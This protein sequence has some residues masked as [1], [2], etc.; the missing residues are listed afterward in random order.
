MLDTAVLVAAERDRLDLD[1]LL[2]EHSRARVMVAATTA[3][4]LLHGIERATEARVRSRRQEFVRY[5][6]ERCAVL[7]FTLATAEH[8]ARLWAALEARGTVIGPHDLLIA[9]TALER[10]AAFATLNRR[11]F[12]RVPG[13]TLVDV[14]PYTTP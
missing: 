8:H 7:P 2:R 14:A 12:E 3:P 11:E 1:A 10:D 4:E 13:L 6:V 5:V 9:A